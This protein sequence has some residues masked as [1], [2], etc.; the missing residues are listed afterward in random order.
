MKLSELLTG[1]DVAAITGPEPAPISAV[2]YNSR[3]VAPGGMFVAI[4]GVKTDGNRYVFDAIERGA[5]VVISEMPRPWNPRWGVVYA[6]EPLEGFVPPRDVPANVTWVEVT[7][8]RKA[9]A[10]IAAHFYGHPA[11]ALQLVGITGTNGKTTISY[12]VDSILRAAGRTSGLAGTIH[13]RTPRGQ[14]AA[15]NTTPESLDL[16]RLFAEIHDAGGTHATLEVSSHALSLDR[17]WGCRFAVAVFT[18]LTREHMDYHKTFEHYF[19]AKR[20]LFEGTGAGAPGV[21]VVNTDD[22]YGRQLAALA[23]RTLTYGL[24]SGADITTKKFALNFQ[25]L[26]FTAHTPAGKIEIASPLVGRINVYNILAAIG[27]GLALGIPNEAIAR[28]IR[29]LQAVPGRFERI[30]LGQPF[31]VVVD[32]AHTDD[33]LRNLLET[34][35]ELAKGG[36]ILT[37]FGCGGNKDRTKRPLMGEVAGQMSDR[38]FITLDNPRTEDPL[39]IANDIVVGLQKAR[40]NYTVEMDRARAIQMALD[41]AH[42]GDIVLLAGKGHEDY[43]AIGT[44]TQPYTDQ[45]TAR[46]CLRRMGYG[47]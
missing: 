44:V 6:T 18:N 16:H 9:L 31:L 4:R 15:P 13:Y 33:A 35:R 23:K 12:L 30:D 11:E 3:D 7:D 24:E 36:L 29:E 17:V 2:A 1:V 5:R 27:A 10:T 26:E 14:R 25:G 45:E 37:L 19:A 47:S 22:A 38:V 21:G 20:Q 34:A 8:A 46:E 40:G 41:E 42:P 32:Y 28:G 39:R 43:Q